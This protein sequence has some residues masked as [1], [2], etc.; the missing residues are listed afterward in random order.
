MGLHIA[1][2]NKTREY[3]H[4]EAAASE[5]IGRHPVH[6]TL[7]ACTEHAEHPRNQNQL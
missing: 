3:W 4:R 6:S 7:A 5:L 1:T 2:A